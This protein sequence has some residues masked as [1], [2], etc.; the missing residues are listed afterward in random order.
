MCSKGVLKQ[1]WNIQFCESIGFVIYRSQE[2]PGPAVR[3]RKKPNFKARGRFGRW[4]PE[5]GIKHDPLGGGFKHLLFSSPT[6]GNDP[7][8]LIYVSNGLVQPPT[9][10]QHLE[11]FEKNHTDLDLDLWKNMM[12]FFQWSKKKT[13]KISLILVGQIH[14]EIRGLELGKLPKGPKPNGEGKGRLFLL[15]TRWWFQICFIFTHIWGR[16]PFWLIFFRWVE[17]TN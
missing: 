3:R 12:Y 10:I 8:S 14:Q 7:I 6:W 16:F 13:R 9:G 5:I 17:T 2:G 4:V 1:P 15:K 11:E